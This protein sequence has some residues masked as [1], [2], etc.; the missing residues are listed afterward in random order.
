MPW[1]TILNTQKL[2]YVETTKV[3][4]TTMSEVMHALVGLRGRRTQRMS[5]HNCKTN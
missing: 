1:V 4:S 5:R 2:A 3:A